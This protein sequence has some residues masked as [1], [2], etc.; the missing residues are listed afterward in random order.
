MSALGDQRPLAVGRGRGNWVVSAVGIAVRRIP[1]HAVIRRARL[2]GV[3]H[4]AADPRKQIEV[5]LRYTP[6]FNERQRSTPLPMTILL[7]SLPAL[8]AGAREER[9]RQVLEPRVRSNG[10][11]TAA[12]CR[13]MAARAF[14]R[15]QVI[16]VLSREAR[17][18][19]DRGVVRLAL[20]GSVARGEAGSDSDVDV[21]IDIDRERHFS[22]IDHSELR[23]FLCDLL[24]RD[25]DVL[26]RDALEPRLLSRMQQDE[27]I[28]F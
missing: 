12:M 6:A 23:L 5:T 10:I 17:A 18:L 20:I 27:T 7:G 26:I 2:P 8:G 24:D 19:R 16:D 9:T 3:V 1:T 4:A 11:G 14:F 13:Q 15:D 25:T 22:L 21:L 28:V